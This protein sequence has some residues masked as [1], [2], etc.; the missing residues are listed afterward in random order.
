M[1]E[2]KFT[3]KNTMQLYNIIYGDDDTKNQPIDFIVVNN[4]IIV[5]AIYRDTVIHGLHGIFPFKLDTS[6]ISPD[7][8]E[9]KKVYMNDRHVT[10]GS[11]CARIDINESGGLGAQEVFVTIGPTPFA[12]STYEVCRLIISSVGVY[13]Q[14]QTNSYNVRAEYDK[15]TKTLYLTD[16][17]AEA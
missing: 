5:E 15:Y 2:H 17:A 1:N 7:K 14:N 11:I 9:G 6:R 8:W 10:D 16:E 13:V 4:K 3:Y 12:T